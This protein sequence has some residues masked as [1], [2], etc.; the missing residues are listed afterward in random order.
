MG[1]SPLHWLGIN[2][3]CFGHSMVVLLLLVFI[4]FLSHNVFVVDIWLCLVLL[5]NPLHSCL[6]FMEKGTGLLDL[7]HF[8]SSWARGPACYYFLPDWPIRP[9]FFPFFL[10]DF[11]S[12]CFYPYFLIFSFIPFCL[13]LLLGSFFLIKK[14]VSTQL[15]MKKIY[16]N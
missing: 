2:W 7:F 4:F 3:W 10:L 15:R 16:Y 11:Y 1:P 6:S 9:S 14:W 13:L 12:L 5:L 8:C